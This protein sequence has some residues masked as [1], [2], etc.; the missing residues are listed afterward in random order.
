M[1]LD[2]KSLLQEKRQEN[3]PG[4][5]PCASLGG[6]RCLPWLAFL[7]G[8]STPHPLPGKAG[9]RGEH[10]AQCEPLLLPQPS[11]AQQLLEQICWEGMGMGRDEVGQA[12]AWRMAV[13][14]GI[15]MLL[16][17]HNPPLACTPVLLRR[18]IWVCLKFIYFYNYLS[19][20]TMA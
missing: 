4:A 19:S 13:G 14:W 5:L 16:L 11:L 9:I 1:S 15:G 10:Q 8:E 12:R 3:I 17:L 18:Q 2:N 20:I 7:S 6:G